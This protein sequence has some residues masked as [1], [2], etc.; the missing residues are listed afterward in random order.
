MSVL[1]RT[2]SLILSLGI[3]VSGFAAAVSADA[4][5]PDEEAVRTNQI[6]SVYS[7]LGEN[8]HD[9]TTTET[10]ALYE[11]I[12]NARESLLDNP[13]IYESNGKQY[14]DAN[15]SSG[16]DSEIVQVEYKDFCG[17]LVNNETYEA[18]DFVDETND[19]PVVLLEGSEIEELNELMQKRYVPDPPPE[20]SEKENYA[21]KFWTWN[22]FLFIV[23]YYEYYEVPTFC[24]YAVNLE[25]GK[26]ARDEDFAKVLGCSE[27]DIKYICYI[28]N[29]YN[30][31]KEDLEYITFDKSWELSAYDVAVNDF[32]MYMDNDYDRRITNYLILFTENN[33]ILA[34]VRGPS[35]NSKG[36]RSALIN[37]DSDSVDIW[38]P[39][40]CVD[41]DLIVGGWSLMYIIDNQ[42]MNM[43]FPDENQAQ[44]I[45]TLT[46]GNI[47]LIES[48]NQVYEYGM[49]TKMDTE[50]VPAYSIGFDDGSDKSWATI[51][52]DMLYVTASDESY[53]LVFEK[54]Y[55][56]HY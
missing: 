12:E 27:D 53:T 20:Y 16:D 33:K 54:A 36:F 52:N 34:D 28:A 14:F 17:N 19:Y 35:L 7:R 21:H 45:E 15:I 26:L 11:S 47:L 2:L 1:K 56:L 37:L 4:V 29:V 8:I 43:Y 25:S 10:E 32:H 46:D 24:T 48:S 18:E 9:G 22:E 49:W 40:Y 42:N 44:V 13:E 6:L 3:S 41:K 5:T 38:N 23:Q 31:Y 50:D 39:E 51:V 55:D 30:F